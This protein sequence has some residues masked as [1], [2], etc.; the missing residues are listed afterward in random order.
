MIS[1]GMICPRL[2]SVLVLYYLQ[3]SMI[4]TPCGPSAVPTGGAGEAWP[5]GIWIF[6]SAATCYLA[7]VVLSEV[8]L[9]LV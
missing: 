6:T 7:M 1:T 9:L 8:R 2:S 5:A 3:K 4:A